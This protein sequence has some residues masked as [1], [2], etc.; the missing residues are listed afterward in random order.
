MS[1]GFLFI[2]FIDELLLF[3]D[4]I[5]FIDKNIFG[6]INNKIENELFCMIGISTR[7]LCQYRKCKIFVM[8]TKKEAANS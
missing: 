3:I 7:L 1:G 4:E 8:S 2:L 5:L 6:I